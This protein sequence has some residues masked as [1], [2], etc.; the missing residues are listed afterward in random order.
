MVKDARRVE[1]EYF[2]KMSV[3]PKVARRSLEPG[4]KDIK[5]RWTNINEEDVGTPDMRS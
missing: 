1:I 4:A 5:V 2:R 3:Y